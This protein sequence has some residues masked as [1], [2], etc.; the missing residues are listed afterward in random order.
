M[1]PF[2]FCFREL[3]AVWK[4]GIFTTDWNCPE[5]YEVVV[6][7][8]SV[9]PVVFWMPRIMCLLF[10]VFVSLFALDVFGAGYGF[11]GTIV[12]LLMHL[13]PTAIILIVLAIAWR[14]E[15]IGAILFVALGVWYVIM[16]WGKFGWPTYLFIAGPL[17]LVG[18]LFLVNWLYRAELQPSI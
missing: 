18:A 10:A 16:A 13:I 14:W 1:T 8:K 15:W 3:K 11:W 12:A 4:C 6:M 5:Y 17:F 7:K 2:L 9:K